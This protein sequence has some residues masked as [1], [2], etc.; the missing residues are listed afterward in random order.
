[1]ENEFNFN[2]AANKEG[3][4]VI[5]TGSAPDIFR[6]GKLA[7]GPTTINGP[8]DWYEK[9]R[10][11]ATEHAYAEIN[12]EA[13]K[14]FYSDD[15]MNES[16]RKI[17][18]QLKIDP[19]LKDLGINS[20]KAYEPEMMAEHLKMFKYFFNNRLAFSELIKRLKNLKADV[21]TKLDNAKDNSGNFK[22]LVD[23]VVQSNIPE[24]IEINI[25]VYI[26][27][28]PVLISVE[29]NVVIVDGELTVRLESSDLYALMDELKFK[30][31]EQEAKRFRDPVTVLYL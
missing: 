19:N 27:M 8:A 23:Q 16:G 24:T 6:P 26:G 31:L 9:H 21:N 3:E 4:C 18:G 30:A 20:G 28:D 13:G 5:R 22:S 11:D 25:P 10:K 15:P 1:M 2:V 29:T 7:L 17:S 14:I 12:I